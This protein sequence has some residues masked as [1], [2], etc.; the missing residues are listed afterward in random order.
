[1]LQG[2]GGTTSS[3]TKRPLIVDSGSED[4]SAAPVR[5]RNEDSLPGCSWEE[6]IRKARE[7]AE[8]ARKVRF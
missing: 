3:T 4:E 5:R 6:R 2:T 8:Q 1:M 7:A